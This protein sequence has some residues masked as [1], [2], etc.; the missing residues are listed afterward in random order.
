MVLQPYFVIGSNADFINLCGL[1]IVGTK[2]ILVPITVS[3]CHSN[4]F[5][6]TV[7][8]EEPICRI[9][10]ISE[11]VKALSLAGESRRHQWRSS[12]G[13][14]CFRVCVVLQ[15]DACALETPEVDSEV[16]VRRAVA[17]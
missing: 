8:R 2:A 1:L 17:V 15:Q 13:I 6:S 11:D 3:R 9:S 12:V 7:W 4:Y 14:V 16:E 5:V 10:A